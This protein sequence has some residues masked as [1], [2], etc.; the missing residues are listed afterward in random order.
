M[1][2]LS[3]LVDKAKAD[4]ASLPTQQTQ[5]G[6]AVA[7]AGER[8]AFT[9]DDMRNSGMSVEEYLKVKDVGLQLKDKI[10]DEIEV[11]IDTTQILFNQS[12]KAGN[13]AVYRK[14]YDSVTCATGGSWD[15]ALEEIRRIDPK[16]RPYMSADIPM[17]LVEDFKDNKG[18]VLLAAG[19]RIGHSLS[20][21]NRAAF[22]DFSNQLDKAELR[23]QTVSVKL[24]YQKMTKTGVNPWG[25]VTF[26][27]LGLAGGD[28]E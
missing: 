2:K 11:E 22:Q 21:T 9:F 18:N 19:T 1:A 13:P 26:T 12:I 7:P 5:T 14:T 6:T 10:V 27:L 28:S 8:R 15:A 17:T 20:T 25:V 24:G 4:S 3:D 23:G 16:A